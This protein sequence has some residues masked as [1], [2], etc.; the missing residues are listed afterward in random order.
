MGIRDSLISEDQSIVCATSKICFLWHPTYTHAHTHTHFKVMQ[1]YRLLYVMAVNHPALSFNQRQLLMYNYLQ[2][3]DLI[4]VE[5]SKY[6]FSG[7][8]S[9]SVEVRDCF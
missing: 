7:S 4:F 8:F 6:S 9:G 2:R 5:K 1:D 3:M